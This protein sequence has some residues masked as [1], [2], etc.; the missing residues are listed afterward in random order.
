MKALVTDN[1]TTN[2]IIR[3][4]QIPLRLRLSKSGFEL[5]GRRI[6]S[7]SKNAGIGLMASIEFT[8]FGKISD[9]IN[10]AWLS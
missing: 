3:A 5:G 1:A 6:V 7:K 10:Y 9:L 8:W 4:A 2:N